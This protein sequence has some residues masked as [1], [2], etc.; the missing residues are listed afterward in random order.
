MPELGYKER[1]FFFFLTQNSSQGVAQ[2][3][4]D[5]CS[6]R[7]PARYALTGVRRLQVLCPGRKGEL[8]TRELNR[9]CRLLNPSSEDRRDIEI[10]G[11]TLRMGG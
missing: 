11:V 6:R 3:I 5:L 7:L 10:E 2:T 4:L 8:G 1:R 9:R